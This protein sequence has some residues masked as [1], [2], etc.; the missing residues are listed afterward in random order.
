V[1]G[2]VQ[3]EVRQAFE[4]ADLPPGSLVVVAVSGG[5]DSTC[6]LHACAMVLPVLASR[7]AA[8]H[9]D[10]SL[11]GHN[12]ADDAQAVRELAARL[13]VRCTLLRRD[14]AAEAAAGRVGLEEAGRLARYRALATQVAQDSAWGAATGHTRDDHAETTLMNLLRGS[15]PAGLSG[16]PARQSFTTA[17][18]G[19][20][21]HSG[22]LG[23]DRPLRVI[24]PLLTVPRTSTT[25]YC[26]EL[27]LSA[28]LDASNLDPT[29]LRNRVRRH[30]VPLLRTYNP[31][32]VDALVGLATL[33]GDDER[34]LERLTTGAW[35]EVEAEAGQVRVSWAVWRSHSAA[36]QRRLL[37]R[38]AAELTDRVL[39]RP[40]IESIR[41]LLSTGL[42]GRELT[43][44]G[45]LR[46]R[47]SRFGF[48]LRAGS[49]PTVPP[50]LAGGLL[51]AR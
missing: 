5:P 42:P 48:A 10:H 51:D 15:G 13:G 6:L 39:A 4:Q 17:G 9:L 26:R 16:I 21:G 24:R 7:V 35:R 2:S 8:L 11:R 27:G 43:L 23:I 22:Q 36:L 40:A 33:I 32:I 44:A 28:R 12:S 19:L 45:G 14:V 1:V 3:A 25:S 29:F 37:R 30:L 18:L 41:R 38:A 49:D 31:S 20:A 46:L 47:T 34:E 50:D